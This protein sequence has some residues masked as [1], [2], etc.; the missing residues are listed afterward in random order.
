MSLVNKPNLNAV[1]NKIVLKTNEL[2]GQARSKNKLI[3]VNECKNTLK[4]NQ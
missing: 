4:I 3:D 2:I 1:V